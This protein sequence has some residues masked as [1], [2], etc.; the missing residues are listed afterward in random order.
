[1][2][3]NQ[4]VIP[5]IYNGVSQQ[6]PI[7]RTPD[8]N[9]D[10]LNTW[11]FLADGV[12]KRPP[13]EH[14]ASLGAF[15]TEAFLHH[16]NRDTSERYIMVIENGEV[17][18]F[19]HET[20]EEKSVDAPQGWGYL[21]NGTYKAT[22]VADYTFIVNTNVVCG[23]EEVGVDTIADPQDLLWINRGSSGAALNAQINPQVYLTGQFYQYEPNPLA[24]SFGGVVSSIEKLP[25]EAPNGVVYQIKGS[26]DTGFRSFYVRRSG[27]VWDETVQNGLRNQP[28]YRTLPHALI[29]NAD[30]TFTFAP[31]SWAPRRVGDED[32]NPRPSFIGRTIRDVFFYQNRLAFLVDENVVFSCA[33]DFGNF[34]R[35]TVLDLIDSD[36][37]DVASTTSNVSL[38]NW[39]VPFVDGIILFSDQTQFSLSNGQDGLTPASAA[40]RPVMHYEVNTDVQPVRIGS[41]LFFCGEQNDNSVVWEYTRLADSDLTSAAEITAHCPRLLPSGI[42]RL[43]AAPNLRALFAID[44]SERIFAYQFY[45]SGNEKIMSAWRPWTFDAPVVSAA[46]L[47]G[48]LYVVLRRGGS[49]FLERVDLEPESKP[50]EQLNQVHLD[51]RTPVDG[52]YNSVLDRTVFSFPYAVDEQSIRIVRGKTDPDRPGSLVDPSSYTF[53]AGNQVAVPGNSQGL[54]TGGVNYTMRIQFS[55][56]YPQ[57]WQGRPVTTGR[58]QLRTWT[59]TFTDTGYFKTEVAP[60]GPAVPPDVE[61]IAPAKMAEFTAKVIDNFDLRLNQPHYASGSYSFQIYGD[62]EQATVALVNDTHVSSTFVSAEWEGF[63]FNRSQ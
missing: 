41:E 38:M 53:P 15:S 14:L 58:L 56:Q 10:E 26:T 8:Q 36:V 11:A 2:A 35:N 39:A 57:D 55:R 1:M 29:S 17:R 42:T 46:F 47:G 31:F 40:I 30:G 52:V 60:Y 5:A 12:G 32:T 37:I 28:D 4:R 13:T 21:A 62:A 45:W 34:W 33:G 25:E 9:E 3:L 22:T 48:Y 44:G 50:E 23:M 54:A 43:V 51:R 18:V 6:P 59:I 20:G 61:D 24:G 27:A 19:D 7:L 49:L 16:I 63:Y